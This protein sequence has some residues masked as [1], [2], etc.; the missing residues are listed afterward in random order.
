MDSLITTELLNL[1]DEKYGD[2]IAKL[3]P[4]MPRERIIGVRT[5]RIR[6]LAKEYF[7]TPE[8]HEHIAKAEHFYYE[9]VNLHATLICMIKDFDEALREAERFLPQIDNWATCDSLSPK[10]F[11]K[12]LDALY[13]RILVWLLSEREYTVRFAIGMLMRYF[14][15]DRFSDEINRLVCDVDRDEYYIKMMQAWYFTTALTK[16]YEATLPY[17][18]ERKLSPWVHSKAIQKAVESCCIDDDTKAYLRSLRYRGWN[19]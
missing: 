15:D 4:T 16:Q 18:A 3:I 5:H 14:L 1:K 19:L 13:D 8:A 10:A 7:G 11:K 2:F 12:N 9:E 17:L 6:K